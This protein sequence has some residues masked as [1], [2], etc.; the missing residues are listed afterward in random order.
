MNSIDVDNL[1]KNVPLSKTI[2]IFLNHFYNQSHT[3]MN[4]TR[5]IFKKLLRLSVRSYFFFF[6]GKLCNQVE[7]L[8][9]G[10]P[11]GSTFVKIFMCFNEKNLA[12]PL[13]SLFQTRFFKEVC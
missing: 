6:D 13:S 1:F 4:M 8:G 3:F 2:S 7:G 9:M 11:P 12:V 5:D 10:L